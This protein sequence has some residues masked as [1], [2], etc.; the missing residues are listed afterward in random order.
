MGDLSVKGINNTTLYAEK[1][2]SQNF[3]A[4]NKK[5]VLSLHYNGDDSYLFINGRRELKFKAK[6]DQIVKK[7]L[8]FGNIS[9]DWTA[10][11]A[12]KMGLWGEIYDFDV[13]YT[14][15]NIGDI[16]NVH[17]YLMKKHNI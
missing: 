2:Y 14:N 9:D 12:Q 15:A 8:C 13:D 5:F 7:I 17:R 10:T 16:Y 6:D 3:T 11:N 4:V 1:L